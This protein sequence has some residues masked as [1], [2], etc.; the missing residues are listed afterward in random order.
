M[1]GLNGEGGEGWIGRKALGNE[2]TFTKHPLRKRAL[3][4]EL[5]IS[6]WW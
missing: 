5:E 3:K 2:K 1:V 6:M 4:Y